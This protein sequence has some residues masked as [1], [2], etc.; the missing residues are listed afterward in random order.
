MPI[1]KRIMLL[2][3]GGLTFRL[4]APHLIIHE[5]KKSLGCARTVC[6]I[7]FFYF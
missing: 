2:K 1:I 3:K 7:Q 4:T 6:C 5:R